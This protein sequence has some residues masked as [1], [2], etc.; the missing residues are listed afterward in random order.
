MVAKISLCFQTFD[1][2]KTSVNVGRYGDPC[3][4]KGALAEAIQGFK[5][6]WI[7]AWTSSSQMLLILALSRPKLLDDL[8]IP[9][10]LGSEKLLAQ[11]ED[12][13]V[14]N[15]Q[16]A[17]FSSSVIV[18]C[19]LARA[20]PYYHSAT[21]TSDFE[22]NVTKC[23]KPLVMGI[24][25]KSFWWFVTPTLEHVPFSRPKCV[26]LPPT[27]FSNLSQKFDTPVQTSKISSH[28]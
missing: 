1:F 8:P 16:T 6:T 12:L 3:S 17:L 26:I 11:K 5:E 28:L 18:L 21:G 7:P 20:L 10:P 22:G 25:L 4:D 14:L 15:N 2:A 19:P 13:L 24:L 9:C 27:P 23:W